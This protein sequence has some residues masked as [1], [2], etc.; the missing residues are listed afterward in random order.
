MDLVCALHQGPDD[1][2][3]ICEK[4]ARAMFAPIDNVF[5]ITIEQMAILE[6]ALVE[7]TNTT[8]IAAMRDAYLEAIRMGVPE[9][10]AQ[11][12]LLGHVRTAFAIVFGFSDFPM[13]DGAKYAV[14]QAKSVI[15]KP[16]WMKNIM[17]LESI[18]KERG[19]DHARDAEVGGKHETWREHVRFHLVRRIRRP[20]FPLSR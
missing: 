4:M 19:G 14:E 12:F 10:A 7:T 20:R 11:S 1:H 5:R 3:A 17:N 18:R 6:P 16:D 15:F 8:L 13:S 9:K 2:Y